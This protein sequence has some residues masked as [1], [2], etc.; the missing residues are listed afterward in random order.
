MKQLLGT[1]PGSLSADTATGVKLASSNYYVISHDPFFGC[2]SVCYAPQ[3]PYSRVPDST[4]SGQQRLG[5][6]GPGHCSRL[7]RLVALR[8]WRHRHS[9]HGT[10]VLGLGSARMC[11]MRC[12]LSAPA[13]HGAAGPPA[14]PA[15][16]TARKHGGLKLSQPHPACLHLSCS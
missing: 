1:A 5:S 2:A 9:Q 7:R 10:A 3:Q 12:D 4:A 11:G 15:T 8:W 16:M 14:A 6:H 13:P